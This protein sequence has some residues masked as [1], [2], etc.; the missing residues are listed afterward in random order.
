MKPLKKSILFFLLIFIFAFIVSAQKEVKQQPNSAA[1]TEITTLK[2]EIGELKNQLSELNNDI[3]ELDKRYNV[4]ETEI[5]KYVLTNYSDWLTTHATIIFYLVGIMSILGAGIF[6]KKIV[7]IE[8]K[9]RVQNHLNND[10]WFEALKL[11]INKQ[12]DQNK[13]KMKMKICVLSNRS[14]TDMSFFLKEND[15]TNVVYH[16][17]S[18]NILDDSTIFKSDFQILIINNQN[19]QFGFKTIK[20]ESGAIVP[21][22]N[23][24]INDL[25]DL[26]KKDYPT[27]AVFYYN[28][29]G[30]TLP[31]KLN[32]GLVSS[33]ANSYASSYHNLLDLMRYKYVVIDHKKI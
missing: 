3:K 28:D 23:T 21:E 13:L 30:F 31:R 4:K 24:A 16:T 22:E 11:K 7:S 29:N 1:Q 9:R 19:N 2:N 17:F 6:I 8:V 33:F 20:L 15:F 32:T 10:E 14:E 5:K 26:I 27:L 12:L 18:D 25:I